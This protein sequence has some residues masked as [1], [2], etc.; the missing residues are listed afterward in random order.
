MAREELRAGFIRVMCTCYGAD[1]YFARLDAQFVHGN[2]KFALHGLPYWEARRGA[3]L[4]RCFFNYVR[5]AGY[6]LAAAACRGQSVS[7]EVREAAIKRLAESLA[8]AAYFVRLCAQGN[9]SLPFCRD[10]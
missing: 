10:R 9:F 1:H 5:F 4:K 7:L 3:W 6:C 8:G 2:F